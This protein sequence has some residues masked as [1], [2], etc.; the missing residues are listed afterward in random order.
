[1]E[2]LSKTFGFSTGLSNLF[3]KKKLENVFYTFIYTKDFEYYVIYH[4][5]EFWQ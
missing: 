1:M 5:L 2:V 3:M 4:A